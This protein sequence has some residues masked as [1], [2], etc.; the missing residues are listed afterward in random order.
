MNAKLVKV[1]AAAAL[2]AMS[3]AVYAADCCG[4]LDCCP[5]ALAC[6]FG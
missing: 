6:C 2:L 3:G 5:Q 1:G 4:G